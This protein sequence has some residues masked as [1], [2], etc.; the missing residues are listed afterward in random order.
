MLSYMTLSRQLCLNIQQRQ[1]TE[2]FADLEPP[3]SHSKNMSGVPA[4]TKFIVW[5][6]KQF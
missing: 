2:L 4:E 5:K 6:T 1:F 3:I